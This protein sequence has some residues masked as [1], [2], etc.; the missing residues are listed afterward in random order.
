MS[1]PTLVVVH[2]TKELLVRAAA[3]RLITALVDAQ[4]SRGYASVVLTGGSVGIGLLAEIAGAPARDAVDWAKV[5]VWWGDERFL[6]A[7]DPGRNETQ[8]RTA[9]LDQVRLDPGRVHPMAASDGPDD[10]DVAADRYAV[11]L[12]AVARSQGTSRDVVPS[13]DVLLLGV[14]PDAHVA[15]LFPEMAGVH[16]TERT[17]VGVHGSPKPPPLRIS[18]TLPAIARAEE[19]WCVV[20]GADKA[21][22]V[23]LAF[24]GA[25]PVQAPAGAVA[26]RR[27]TLWL[28]DRPAAQQVPASMIRP[29]S[30]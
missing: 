30:P 25:G 29:A 19:V 26:G 27:R 23:G 14:G 22:A 21:A 4:A 10:V 3:A 7:G 17:V 8:A 16:E 11:E 13:F 24:S 5:D 28:L 18:M 1:A 2:S 9:L 15:S 6:P 20:S 12:A